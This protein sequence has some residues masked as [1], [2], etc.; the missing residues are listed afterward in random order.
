MR[1]LIKSLGAILLAA[2]CVICSGYNHHLLLENQRRNQ[3][4]F[5]DIVACEH[6]C[7]G[8]CSS[9]RNEN[10]SICLFWSPRLSQANSRL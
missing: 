2:P 5:H 1:S 7:G 3:Q 9:Q 10:A 6:H 4:E 8:C